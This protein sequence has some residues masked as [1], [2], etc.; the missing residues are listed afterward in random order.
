[1]PVE[2]SR[3]MVLGAGLGALGVAIVG[4]NQS[5]AE[6]ATATGPVRSD[7]ATS[8]GKVF[9]VPYNGSTMNLTL[10][11]VQDLP[12]STAANSK[13]C[14][15]LLF[16]PAGSSVLRD[17]IY[18]LKRAGVPTYSLFLGRVGTARNVQAVVN[19]AY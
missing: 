3:R 18:P 7:Y 5:S 8:V 10:T 12:N 2:P 15:S 1:M 14:F 6:A 16:T 11:A 13:Y 19:R 17:G 4:V 9:T